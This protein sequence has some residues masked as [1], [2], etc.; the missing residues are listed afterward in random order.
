VV[1]Y[2]PNIP[3]A[4]VAMLATTS[5]GAIWAGCA[6][7]FGWRGAS[8]RLGQLEPTVLFAVDGY[9]YG[10]KVYDR[11][12]E[13]RGL[14]REL[15]TLEHLVYLPVHF[16]EEPAAGDAVVNAVTWDQVLAGPLVPAE[17]FECEQVPFDHP[18]WVDP[19]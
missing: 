12:E 15:R 7:E 8:D 10:G 13:V 19:G 11:R 6:P 17:Q 3:E 18:L 16:P 2:L 5:V 14:V 4:M 1:G 9:R